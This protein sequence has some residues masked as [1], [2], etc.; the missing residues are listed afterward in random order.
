MWN[1]GVPIRSDPIS[2]S[3]WHLVDKT[4]F[5]EIDRAL[6]YAALC[7]HFVQILTNSRAFPSVQMFWNMNQN[8]MVVSTP[9][10][11]FMRKKICMLNA[12]HYVH[13]CFRL[14]CHILTKCK[15]QN[16]KRQINFAEI[17]SKINKSCI[18][19]FWNV[20]NKLKIADENEWTIY[21]RNM[22]TYTQIYTHIQIEIF[23]LYSKFST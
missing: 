19:H 7:T 18:R 1:V 9:S 22:N 11:C 23:V 17:S 13:V 14:W 5:H 2:M 15:K 21:D 12:V 4:Q 8:Q 20:T 16:A 10:L 6:S 3:N